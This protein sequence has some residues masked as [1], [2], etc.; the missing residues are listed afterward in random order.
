M[1]TFGIYALWDHEKGLS[2]S[3]S[4]LKKY[5]HQFIYFYNC[6]NDSDGGKLIQVVQKSQMI[7]KYLLKC[8]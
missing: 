7:L 1:T 3:I 4:F 8:S 2:P 6:S 5:I